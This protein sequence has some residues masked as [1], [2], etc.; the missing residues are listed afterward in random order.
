M[1]SKTNSPYSVAVRLQV[2][3]E[4]STLATSSKVEIS[5]DP[6]A[7]KIT[8]SEEDVR[9]KYP[10]DYK[11]LAKR[12]SDRYSNFKQDKKFNDIRKE[13]LP[14]DRYVKSRYLDPGNPKSSKKDFYNSNVIQIFDKHYDKK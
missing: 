14:D 1:D 6:D 10:W 4:K 5:K 7:V 12:L 13:L 3:V 8:I 11:E 9:E 2:K